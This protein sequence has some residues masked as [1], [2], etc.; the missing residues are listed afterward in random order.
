MAAQLERRYMSR[1][2]FRSYTRTRRTQRTTRLF[3]GLRCVVFGEG[4]YKTVNG[5]SCCCSRG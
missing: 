2:L 4:G 5:S 1:A 3:V